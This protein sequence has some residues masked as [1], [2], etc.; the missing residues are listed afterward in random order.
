[1]HFVWVFHVFLQ[2]KCLIHIL[3]HPYYTNPPFSNVFEDM[4]ESQTKEELI[5]MKD[6][7]CLANILK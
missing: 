2:L 7:L 4:I 5:D 3:I 1:M 6:G